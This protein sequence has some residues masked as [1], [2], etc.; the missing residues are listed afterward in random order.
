MKL[1]PIAREREAISI[2]YELLKERTPEQSISHR[3]MP[4]MEEHTDFV[5]SQ[6]YHV[7]YLIEVDDQ[8]V[9]SVYLSK[10]REIGIFI[11][12]SHARKGHGAEAVK[13]LM[14]RWPGH[15]L[16]NI[17][18]QNESSIEFF[19]RLGF[20]HIQNTYEMR[21]ARKEEVEVLRDVPVS[22]NP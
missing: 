21:V 14:A 15:F 6:P 17:N 2:L 20:K 22:S 12:K 4:T 9:G 13:M 3:G 1:V 5:R 16:A 8:Y 18:P 7:W 10:S 19:K 11:F